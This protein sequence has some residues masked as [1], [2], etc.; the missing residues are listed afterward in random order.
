MKGFVA[1]LARF[2]TDREFGVGVLAKSLREH[3]PKILQE[4]YDF[5]L[6]VFPKVPNP[7]PE[8]AT[9]FLDLMQIKERRDWKEFVDT[10]IMDDLEREGFVASVYK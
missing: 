9:V 3:D 7:G 5:W 1:G 10:S 4:S 6:K 8:D 2:R